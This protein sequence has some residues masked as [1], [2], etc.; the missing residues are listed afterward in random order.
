MTAEIHV[1]KHREVMCIVPYTRYANGGS[2]RMWYRD[3][4]DSMTPVL[5]TLV[6]L[7]CTSS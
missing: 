6:P 5:S 4:R 7:F 1:S 3:L 2:A